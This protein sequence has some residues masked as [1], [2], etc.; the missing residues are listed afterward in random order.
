V[1]RKIKIFIRLLEDALR[2]A[3]NSLHELHSTESDERDIYWMEG[4]IKG[5]NYYREQATNGT[6]IPS[7][8]QITLGLLRNFLDWLS[9]DQYPDLVAALYKAEQY[10]QDELKAY[11]DFYS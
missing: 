8:G 1:G 9:Q 10:Y 11:G 4:V 6:L 5:L 3:E 2:L 7:E